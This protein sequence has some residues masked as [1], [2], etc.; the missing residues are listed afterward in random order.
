MAIVMGWTRRIRSAEVK[1]KD[2]AFPGAVFAGLKIRS[3]KKSSVSWLAF[4]E[5]SRHELRYIELA[6][7]LRYGKDGALL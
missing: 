5:C 6:V 2:S 1:F 3:E 7:V 4:S